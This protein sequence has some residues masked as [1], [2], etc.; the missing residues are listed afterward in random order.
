MPPSR[1]RPN[2]RTLRASASPCR[3]VARNH[4]PR[5]PAIAHRDRASSADAF[6]VRGSRFSCEEQGAAGLPQSD[7][8]AGLELE[9]VRRRRAEGVR[10]LREI[11]YR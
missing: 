10:R 11:R 8:F 3:R 6:G 4:N 2:R 5:L 1:T 7:Q 9:R